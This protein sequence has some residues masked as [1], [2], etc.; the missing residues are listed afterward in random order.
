MGEVPTKTGRRWDT[1]WEALLHQ[2]HLIWW[3]WY[4]K[5]KGKLITSQRGGL[6]SS[7]FQ[8]GPSLISLRCRRQRQGG[9]RLR[10]VGRGSCTSC[11]SLCADYALI[12]RRQPPWTNLDHFQHHSHHS[13]NHHYIQIV[14]WLTDSNRP[15]PILIIIF[16]II[17]ILILI[18]IVI[19]IVCKLYLD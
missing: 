4:A 3:G 13:Q 15:G 12:N 11:T 9:D 16:K 8:K 6:L 2:L 19:L 14:P 17:L 18:I 7:W 1:G 5:I 10:L